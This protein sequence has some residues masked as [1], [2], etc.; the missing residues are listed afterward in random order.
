[1]ILSIGQIEQ[2]THITVSKRNDVKLNCK[3]YMKPFNYVYVQIKQMM[4]DGNRWIYLK[5]SKRMII[6]YD[7]PS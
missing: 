3:C 1:M 5:V 6:K 7:Y 2:F 4:F